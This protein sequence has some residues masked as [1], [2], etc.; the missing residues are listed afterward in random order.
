ML[1]GPMYAQFMANSQIRNAAEAMLN[2]VQHAQSTAIRGKATQ[3]A[4]MRSGSMSRPLYVPQVG[5]T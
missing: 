5:Q 2:G 3:G 4:W 1:A